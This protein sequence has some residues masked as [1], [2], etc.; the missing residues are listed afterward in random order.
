[1][2]KRNEVEV[3]LWIIPYLLINTGFFLTGYEHHGCQREANET[4]K[5]NVWLTRRRRIPI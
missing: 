3:F 2:V 4:P 1:M 5:S